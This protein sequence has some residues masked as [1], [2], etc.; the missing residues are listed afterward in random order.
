MKKLYLIILATFLTLSLAACG[1]DTDDEPVPYEHNVP[2]AY[3]VILNDL[4]Y[5][6]YLSMNNPVVTITVKDIGD[7]KLQLFPSVAPI[8]VDNFIKYIQDGAYENNEFHRVIANFMIQGGQLEE[9][10]CSIEGEMT[11][12]PGT[13]FTNELKHYKGVLSMARVGGNYDSGSSQFFIMH[14]YTQSL[15]NEYAS[16]GGV[17]NGFHIVDYIA[18]LQVENAEYTVTPIIIENI[19]VDLN[20][21]VPNDRVCAT[22]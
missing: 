7:I 9:P 22:D 10:V 17:V 18:S 15:D 21:Y 13:D 11:N 4:G 1:D 12:N 20:G 2:D 16:F 14:N 8:S 19:T 6:E 5:A 3:S